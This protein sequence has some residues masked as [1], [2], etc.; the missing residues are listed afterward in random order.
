[1]MMMMMMMMVMVMNMN[2]EQFEHYQIICKI[3][4]ILDYII[5]SHVAGTTINIFEDYWQVT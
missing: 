2:M 3:N 4:I 1:M 5:L